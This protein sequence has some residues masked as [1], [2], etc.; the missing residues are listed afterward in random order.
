MYF[1]RLHTN[2]Y[3]MWGVVYRLDYIPEVY[4]RYSYKKNSQYCLEIDQEIP[5]HNQNWEENQY[6][7]SISSLSFGNLLDMHFLLSM[8]EH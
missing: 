7:G 4:Q 3:S 6:N 1:Y 8:Q 2:I 5:L